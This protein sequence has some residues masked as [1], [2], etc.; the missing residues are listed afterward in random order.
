MTKLRKR[1]AQLPSPKQPRATITTTV[2]LD[3]L[4]AV[5]DVCKR[6]GSKRTHIIEAALRY[7]FASITTQ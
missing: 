6:V 1:Q 7:Y 4:A 3:M 2:P 5:D